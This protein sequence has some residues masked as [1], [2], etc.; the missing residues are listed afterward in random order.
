MKLVLIPGLDGTGDLFEPLLSEMRRV[1]CQVIAYPP[2]QE[3]DYAAHEA[4]VR[5]RLPVDDHFLLAESFSGPVGISI[6]ASP[7]PHLRGLILCASFASN[8]LPAFGPLR[9]VFSALPAVKIPPALFAPFLYGGYGTRE[10]RRLHARAMAKVPATTLRA[11]VA[12]ILSVDYSHKLR[13][14]ELPMLYLQAARDRLVP[15][16]ALTRIQ[17]IRQDIEVIQIDGPH[18]LLQTRPKACAEHLVE[19]L[20]R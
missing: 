7:P 4:Y 20:R 17:R 19:F 6:A 16:S 5:E 8:P 11:R 1:D 18:F 14:V 2:D 3:M 12:A 13:T 10:L 9:K 15:R